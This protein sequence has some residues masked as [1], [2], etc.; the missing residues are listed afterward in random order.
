MNVFHLKVD[1]CEGCTKNITTCAKT[2][3]FGSCGLDGTC[4][5]KDGYS[6]DQCEHCR[7]FILM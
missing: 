4:Q 2:C 5:C 3:Y 7:C 1:P 6:G